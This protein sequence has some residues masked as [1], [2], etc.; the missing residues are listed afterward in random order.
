MNN[1]T[2]NCLTRC[3][4]HRRLFCIS[5][6]IA[7]MFFGSW[8]AVEAQ[9]STRVFV[10]VTGRSGE[11]VTDLSE[12]EFVVKEND[13]YC[14]IF[15]AERSTQ[16][17]RIALL[18]DNSGQVEKVGALLPL[19]DALDLF[20]STIQ[21]QHEVAL[22]TIGG[23]IQWRVDFTS[24]RTALREAAGRIFSDSGGGPI[25]IDG[26]KETWE[27]Q[28]GDGDEW[29]VFV[30]V[31][32]DGPESSD[33]MIARSE[34]KYNEFVAELVEGSATVH[35]V[36]LSTRGGSMVT[37]F[38]INLTE[39]TNGMYRPL[40]VATGL[41]AALA[42]LALRMNE[43][44]QDVADRYELEFECPGE[45]GAIVQAGVSRRGATVQLY[46]DRRMPQ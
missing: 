2:A 37:N 45:P 14:G 12:D 15:S 21:S 36:L 17:M 38:A 23:N 22:F 20:L 3:V 8:V 27:R 24:D 32:T 40:V 5:L 34:P 6:W 44:Y 35:V 7:W 16:T 13:V 4:Q 42:E 1:R 18:V 39:N 28:Y 29:P 30:V 11:P 46:A 43:H 31:M 26:I 25:F 10:H 9:D 33:S 41:S 19:R